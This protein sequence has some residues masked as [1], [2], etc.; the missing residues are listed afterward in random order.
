MR[1]FFLIIICCL[2]FPI[3]TY[4]QAENSPCPEISVIGPSG[5]AAPTS[6]EPVTYTAKVENAENFQLEYLWEISAGE[7]ISG[8]GTPSIELRAR[9]DDPSNITVT[10]EI[11]GLPEGCPNVFSETQA[12]ARCEPH[13]CRDTYGKVSLREE[14]FQMDQVMFQLRQYSGSSVVFYLSFRGKPTQR[15]INARI[16]R[17]L[18]AFALRKKLDEL[19]RIAFVVVAGKEEYTRICYF[20]ETQEKIDFNDGSV[21]KGADV[22]LKKLSKSKKPKR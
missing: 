5:I 8:Q 17:M 22:D 2:A 7:I 10:V 4:A 13:N 20:S 14:Y 15:Q 11:K 9:Q 19:G 21:I 16:L 12:V 6:G 3:N 18:E 1:Q